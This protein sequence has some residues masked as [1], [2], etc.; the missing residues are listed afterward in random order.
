MKSGVNADMDS[1]SNHHSTCSNNKIQPLLSNESLRES[2][3]T[4]NRSQVY[5]KNSPTFEATICLAY[6]RLGGS[7]WAFGAYRSLQ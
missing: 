6:V 4:G 2:I 3:T 7:L 5:A 1:T